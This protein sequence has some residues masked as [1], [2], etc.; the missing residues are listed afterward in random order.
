V[1]AEPTFRVDDIAQLALEVKAVPAAVAF[2]RD[3]LG[4]RPLPIPAPPT[5]AF[6]ACGTTRLMLS[7]PE[8]KDASTP[9]SLIYFRVSDIRAAHAV[10]VEHGAD[11]IRPPHLVAQLPDHDLWMTFF[12]DPSG[13]PLA[14]MAESPRER[15]AN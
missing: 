2:Y 1:S 15:S 7:L 9:G 6:F 14:F 8:G 5:M 13:N 10:L 11:V 3:V 12:R 4:L